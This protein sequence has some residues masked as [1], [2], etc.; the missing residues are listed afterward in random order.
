MPFKSLEGISSST[1]LYRPLPVRYKAVIFWL[2]HP[3]EIYFFDKG[4][5]IMPAP[6]IWG[7]CMLTAL[8]K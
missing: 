2:M 1:H 6:D 8:L 4:Y 5:L 7:S 3:E